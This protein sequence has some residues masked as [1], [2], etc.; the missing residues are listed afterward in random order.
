[1]LTLTLTSKTE[2]YVSKVLTYH[3]VILLI[4]SNPDH[5]PE[6]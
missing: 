3:A 4:L 5:D 6:A 1:M 2:K